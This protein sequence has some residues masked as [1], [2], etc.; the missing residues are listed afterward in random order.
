MQGTAQKAQWR[1][2]PGSSQSSSASREDR[3][4]LRSL[5]MQGRALPESRVGDPLGGASPHNLQTPTSV[6]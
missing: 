3:G 1:R 5:G 2:R 4:S 6:G